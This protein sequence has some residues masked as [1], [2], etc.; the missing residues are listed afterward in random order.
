MYTE[1]SKLVCRKAVM[2]VSKGKNIR[3]AGKGI[4]GAYLHPSTTTHMHAH[5]LT[6]F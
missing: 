1:G 6:M 4:N 2:H 5:Q 3:K